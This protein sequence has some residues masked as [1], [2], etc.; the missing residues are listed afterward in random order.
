MVLRKYKMARN[1]TDPGQHRES[2]EKRLIVGGV[3]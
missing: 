1:S 2:R 3:Q